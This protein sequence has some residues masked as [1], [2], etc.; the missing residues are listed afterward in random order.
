MFNNAIFSERLCLLRRNRS[1]TLQQVG[2]SVSSTRATIG[3]LENGNKN[4]SVDMLIALSLFFDVSTDY[5][6]GLS[7][8]PA[9]H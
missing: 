1:L 5:L 7:D 6:L 9:R 3:N 4:P 2:A 8:D